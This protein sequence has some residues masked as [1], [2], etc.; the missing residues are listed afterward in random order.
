M[1]NKKNSA[2]K[3]HFKS[4][5]AII[6]PLCKSLPTRPTTAAKYSVINEYCTMELMAYMSEFALDSDHA[7]IDDFTPNPITGRTAK[8][9]I[10]DE[11]LSICVCFQ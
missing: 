5:V 3:K 10:K 6:V 9:E 2:P 11:L 8:K 1:S 4:G 7:S